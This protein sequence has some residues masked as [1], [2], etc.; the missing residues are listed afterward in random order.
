[1]FP[2]LS[3]ISN[4]LP[5]YNRCIFHLSSSFSI[6]STESSSDTSKIIPGFTLLE[7]FISEIQ[8]SFSISLTR[9]ISINAPVS[10]FA[11]NLAGI[12]F[13]LFKTSRSFSV[14]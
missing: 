9:K 5:R 11:Y 14:R 7:G 10:F 3:R 2:T 4:I 13:V 12:T 8:I 6:I 1:M